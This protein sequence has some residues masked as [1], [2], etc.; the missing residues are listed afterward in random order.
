MATWMKKLVDAE[1]VTEYAPGPHLAELEK[2]FG[3]TGAVI[4]M[5][6]VSV[7]MRGERLASATQGCIGF[8][9]DAVSGGYEVGLLLWNTGVAGFAEPQP[10]GAG[11]RRLLASAKVDGGTNVVPALTRAGEHLLQMQVTDRVVA[12]FGDGDLGDRTKAVSTAAELRASGVRIVTLGLGELS[13]QALGV[14]ATDPD[15]VPRAASAASLRE[16]I[17]GMAKGL[18]LRKR[19]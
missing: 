7:S 18:T 14:I 11:A 17:R 5:L 16:D 9:D 15:D 1:G 19:R 13:A 4:L 12:V 3:G 2:R 6:D 8:I 10:G